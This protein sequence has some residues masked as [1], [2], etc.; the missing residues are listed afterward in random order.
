MKKH[1]LTLATKLIK[2][3]SWWMT[4][5]IEARRFDTR[6]FIARLPAEQVPLHDGFEATDSLWMPVG[7]CVLGYQEG[8]SRWR[9]RPW[10]R[11]CQDLVVSQRSMRSYQVRARHDRAMRFPFFGQD[12]RDRAVLLLPG[13]PDYPKEQPAVRGPARVVL[14]NGQLVGRLMSGFIQRIEQ[15]LDHRPQDVERAAAALTQVRATCTSI[16]TPGNTIRGWSF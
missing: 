6:F 9:R 7:Q 16:R 15:L 5:V 13:D 1:R 14:E 3:W 4:P 2:P 12:S 8:G 10:R 11:L